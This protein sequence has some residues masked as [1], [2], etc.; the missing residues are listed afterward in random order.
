MRKFSKINESIE[1]KDPI[2]PSEDVKEFKEKLFS[3]RKFLLSYRQ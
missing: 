2:D 1:D 3:T